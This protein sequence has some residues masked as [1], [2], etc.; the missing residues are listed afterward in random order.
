MACLSEIQGQY[1]SPWF[2]KIGFMPLP[3]CYGFMLAP[4]F[5][6][7]KRNPKRVRKGKSKNSFQ[8]WFYNNC[9]RG[10]SHPKQGEG[11]PSSFP[12]NYTQQHL[13]I[14]PPVTLN[15]ACEHLRFISIYFVH[16]L[17]GCVPG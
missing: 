1:E 16:S 15:C 7:I 4:V 10:S 14:K 9:H 8:H 12:R 5:A 11:P 13:S 2:L 17:A 6:N 3:F